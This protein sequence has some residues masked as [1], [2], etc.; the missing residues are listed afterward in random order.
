MSSFNVSCGLTHQTISPGDK[1]TLILVKQAYSF[2][3]NGE[4]DGENLFGAS[5]ILN[6]S[7]PDAYW[8]PSGRLLKV[9]YE[10][11]GYFNLVDEGNTFENA[12]DIVRDFYKKNLIIDPTDDD[13]EQLSFNFQMMLENNCP[14]LYMELIIGEDSQATRQEIFD[15]LNTAMSYIQTFTR[16]GKMFYPSSKNTRFST[17]LTFPMHEVAYEKMLEKTAAFQRA[18]GY[19]NS[20]EGKIES[21]LEDI[22]KAIAFNHTEL[23]S[24]EHLHTS[25]PYSEVKMFDLITQ[26]LISSKRN[27]AVD[28]AHRL[29]GRYFEMSSLLEAMEYLD[30]KILPQIFSKDSV[31]N[32]KGM[33]FAQLVNEV[34]ESLSNKKTMRP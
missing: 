24:F 4:A 1:C 33:E 30:L 23:K 7:E 10:D 22:E 13:P 34:A 27:I 32:E 26:K 17:M 14:K 16:I 29:F 20:I 8:L 15:E 2:S 19:D 28:H 6:I 18:D 21:L 9:E 11:V 12:Y 31:N 3:V 5:T 25:M